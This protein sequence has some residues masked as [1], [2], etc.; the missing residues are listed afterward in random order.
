MSLG[1][2]GRRDLGVIL[3]FTI[4]AQGGCLKIQFLLSLYQEYVHQYY[5]LY[6]V[7]EY[8]ILGNFHVI[9]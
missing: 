1:Q 3:T 6:T 7:T 4:A 9:S 5:L 8:G 2:F